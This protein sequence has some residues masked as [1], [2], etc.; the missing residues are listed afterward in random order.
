MGLVTKSTADSVWLG[1]ALLHGS[2]RNQPAEPE[3]WVCTVRRPAC[4]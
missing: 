1:L 2:V 3:G 4:D